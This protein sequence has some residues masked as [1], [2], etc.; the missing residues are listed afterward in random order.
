MLR[1]VR[2]GRSSDHAF[3]ACEQIGHKGHEVSATKDTKFTKFLGFPFVNFVFFVASLFVPSWPPLFADVRLVY[4]LS[5]AMAVPARD[6]P[7]FPRR[8]TVHVFA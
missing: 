6:T 3:R 1:F 2:G 5:L 7:Q 4:R 8:A